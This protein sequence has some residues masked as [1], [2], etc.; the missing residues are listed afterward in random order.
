M[1]LLAGILLLAGQFTYAD[2]CGEAQAKLDKFIFENTKRKC[3]A[4]EE[5][6]GFYIRADSCAAPVVLAKKD[7]TT[8]F[9]FQLYKAQ[10][11][12]REACSEKWAKRP[13][14]SPTPFVA[15]C[16]EKQCIDAAGTLRFPR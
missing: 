14:C 15:R 8:R 9:E 13:A 10:K 6:G 7:F 4:D 12:V 1:W 3:T 11:Q 5:C 2:A 16:K